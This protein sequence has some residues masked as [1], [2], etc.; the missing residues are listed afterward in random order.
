[1]ATP[2]STFLKAGPTITAAPPD[3]KDRAGVYST[4]AFQC[5]SSLEEE[6][7]VKPQFLLSLALAVG[8]SACAEPSAQRQPETTTAPGRGAAQPAGRGGAG[9]LVGSPE[10]QAKQA[11]LEKSTPQLKVTEEVLQAGRSPARR[12][13]RRSASPRTPP[14]TCSCS[15]RTGKTATVKGSAASMLFEFDPSLKFV[16]EW[17]PNNYAAGLRAH[18]ARRQGRQRLDGRR[19]LEHGRQVP[20]RRQRGDGARPEGRAARLARAL[21]RGRRE[22][23]RH[24][25]GAAAASSIVRPT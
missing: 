23:R 14:A 11:E 20:S 24:A 18:R 22:A 6:A 21:R 17:G 8:M 13:A 12:S 2:S 7:M 3:F 25:A 9:G 16:K 10:Q 4:S 19:R 15:R 1:M 5:R